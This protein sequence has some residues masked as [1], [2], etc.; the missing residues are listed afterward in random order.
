MEDLSPEE[1]AALE[2]L[3]HAPVA[4]VS[5]DVVTAAELGQW[6]NLA[7]PRV[8]VLARDGRISRRGDGRFDLKVAIRGYC[9]SLRL[10]SGGSALAANP[11]L[12]TQKV[13]PARKSADKVAIQNA[14]ARGEMIPAAE[15]AKA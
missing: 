11:E 13:R 4:P 1:L 6:L 2:A 12:K 5:G 14:R 8:S 15:V 9:E 3:I 7:A 10:K